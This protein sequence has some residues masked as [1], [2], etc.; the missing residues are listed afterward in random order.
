VGI[1][2]PEALDRLEVGSR[3]YLAD[4]LITLVVKNKF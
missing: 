2:Y 1:N 3:I 4:G